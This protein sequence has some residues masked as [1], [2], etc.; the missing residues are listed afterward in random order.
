M[1]P[2]LSQ[3]HARASGEVSTPRAPELVLVVFRAFS[4]G[5]VVG[6]LADEDGA[7]KVLAAAGVMI[8]W[9]GRLDPRPAVLVRSWRT[10]VNSAPQDCVPGRLRV[11]RCAPGH[12]NGRSHPTVCPER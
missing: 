8:A 11:V 3:Q 4:V 7:L 10:W 6:V 9:T 12:T 2:S 1:L 5:S